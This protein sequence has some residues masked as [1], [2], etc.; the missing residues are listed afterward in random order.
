MTAVRQVI[1]DLDGTLVDSLPGIAFSVDE[2]LR[3]CGFP[4]LAQELAPVIGPP[5]RDIL[6]AVSGTQNRA[7]LDRLESSFRTSYDTGGWRRTMCLA[8]VPD[9][10][11]NLMTAG[12][13][14]WLA[15]NKPARPTGWILRELHLDAFFREAACRD[16]R[17]PPFASKGEMLSDLLTRRGLE[18]DECLM[19]GDTAE[20]WR[21]AQVAGIACAIAGGAA[22]PYECRRI[23]NWNELESM[24]RV[25]GVAA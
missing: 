1:F 6:A 17:T 5:V 13:D 20:D 2:A 9:M 25:E 15:T 23:A 8:G 19:V 10:L 3:A 11:W 24:L 22:V 12:M 4:P 14:L 18:R 7:V 16:S 21:A